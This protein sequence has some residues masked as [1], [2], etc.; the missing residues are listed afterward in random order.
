MLPQELPFVC[1]EHPMPFPPTV[2]FPWISFNHP[3]R[4][5][6]ETPELIIAVMVPGVSKSIVLEAV[7]TA[8]ETEDVQSELKEKGGRVF[9]AVTV[10]SDKYGRLDMIRRQQEL[11]KVIIDKLGTESVKV[12]PIV[13]EPQ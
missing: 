8:F 9:G 3:N 4:L 7:I 6:A 13:L 1:W 2:R 5:L 11:W 12:G 10:N